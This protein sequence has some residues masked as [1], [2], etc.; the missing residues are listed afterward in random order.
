MAW[1]VPG[2]SPD[3][4]RVYHLCSM[5][6]KLPKE[7]RKEILHLLTQAGRRL[8]GDGTDPYDACQV[9][10]DEDLEAIASKIVFKEATVSLGLNVEPH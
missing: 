1:A 9:P 5:G 2:S 3:E 4:T 8:Q 10:S 6:W 7:A